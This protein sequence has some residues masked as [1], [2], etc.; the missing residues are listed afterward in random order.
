MQTFTASAC[1]LLGFERLC[2]GFHD[3]EHEGENKRRWT[4]GRALLPAS[5]WKDAEGEFFLRIDLAFAALPRW[6]APVSAIGDKATSL[7]VA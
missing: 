7:L 2:V 4:A 1:W 5:L 6:A 3:V